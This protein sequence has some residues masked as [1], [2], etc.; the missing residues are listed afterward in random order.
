MPPE[1]LSL[2]P[3][4]PAQATP[5]PQHTV[6]AGVSGWLAWPS[7]GSAEPGGG[8]PCQDGD[9]RGG[10]FR[11]GRQA[12]LPQF[13][14]APASSPSS[15]TAPP[16]SGTHTCRRQE[17]RSPGS[18]SPPWTDSV[19]I[20]ASPPN[21]TSPHHPGP[22]GLSFPSLPPAP[23]HVPR[24]SGRASSPI[25][26]GSELSGP[27]LLRAKE[28]SGNGCEASGLAPTGV[29]EGGGWA[30]WSP[31]LRP[32]RALLVWPSGS[33]NSP[34]SRIAPGRSQTRHIGSL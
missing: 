32:N 7:V 23:G 28:R 26:A 31:H 15:H 27:H 24:T 10:G 12:Q 29:S 9:D 16:L 13:K 2:R 22:L 21:G 6:K 5:G 4:S 11:G 1:S 3:Q 34:P 33:R 30:S 25:K 20:T 8:I 14:R 18:G 19:S 17:G